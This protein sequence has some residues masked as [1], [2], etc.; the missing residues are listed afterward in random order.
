MKKSMDSLNHLIPR[1]ILIKS[2]T[3]S[4]K[5]E[6]IIMRYTDRFIGYIIEGWAAG[7]RYEGEE[8]MFCS[9]LL[10]PGDFIGLGNY[11]LDRTSNWEILAVSENVK[12][13]IFPERVV[14]LEL[15]KDYNISNFIHRQ[16]IVNTH[17]VLTGYYIFARGG[18]KAFLA[19]LM[20]INSEEGIVYFRKYSDIMK[21]MGISESM[22]YR[23]TKEFISKK[24]IIKG[25]KHLH[26]LN[27]EALIDCYREY[28]YSSLDRI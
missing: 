10:K 26:I 1:E 19:Y 18:A 3:K 17:R 2:Y 28:I 9:L 20:I 23:I 22:L 15:L 11:Y 14:S 7:V 25:R 12:V 27:R 4:Y 5:E 21:I 13:I 16:V 24:L 8:E 6:E